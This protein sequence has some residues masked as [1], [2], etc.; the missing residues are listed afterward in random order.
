M[1][2]MV[3]LRAVTAPAAPLE[4]EPAILDEATAKRAL[5]GMRP[6]VLPGWSR[7]RMVQ[8]EERLRAGDACYALP[9]ARDGLKSFVWVARGRSVYVREI[10]VHVRVPDDVVY[11]Y[12]A[13]TVP[14]SRGKGLLADVARGVV[15]DFYGSGICSGPAHCEVWIAENNPSSLRAFSKAGFEPYGSLR[16]VS[17]GPW[18]FLR[19][20]DPR[21]EPVGRGDGLA[22]GTSPEP[23]RSGRRGGGDPNR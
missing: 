2:R 13:F 12:D 15:R 4:K 5:P 1:I 11:L 6:S 10:G 14:G 18:R 20:G 19:S 22:R 8:V 21:M 3:K 23:A 9:N 7:R 17:V 16:A